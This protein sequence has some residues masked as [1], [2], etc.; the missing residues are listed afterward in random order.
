MS[1]YKH[2]ADFWRLHLCACMCL[3]ADSC[4]CDN[5]IQN[6]RLITRGRR[7]PHCLAVK[8]VKSS[9]MGFCTLMEHALIGKTTYVFEMAKN[10]FCPSG[11]TLADR[12]VTSLRFSSIW[13]R[14][15][16]FSC[17]RTPYHTLDIHRILHE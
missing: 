12:A 2:V 4:V 16:L 3:E 17:N 11:G 13:L 6:I 9:V 10:S 7:A 1:D 15:L 5:G 14:T 8:Q